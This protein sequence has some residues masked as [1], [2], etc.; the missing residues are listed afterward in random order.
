MI[1]Q[2]LTGKVS[3]VMPVYNAALFLR[4][5]IQSI[6]SQTFSDFEFLIINDG[7]TDDS[8]A[9]IEEIN[10]PRIKHV[11]L[12]QN[13]GI[14][15]ALNLGIE[16][17]AGEYLVRMDADD[18][19]RT[20]RLEM[21]VSFMD[22]NPEI[23]L[24]GSWV[25]YFGTKNGLIKTP[26]SH[27]DI[28]WTLLSGSAIFHPSVIMRMSIIRN[29]NIRYSSQYLHAEDFA[30]WVD[31]SMKTQL[32]NIP[33]P[34][35]SYRFSKSSVSSKFASIQRNN[36]DKIRRNMHEQLLGENLS[37]A[38]WNRIGGDDRVPATVAR[39]I[40]VYTAMNDAQS[41]FPAKE[42]EKKLNIRLKQL[43][44]QKGC[45]WSSR[46]WLLRNSFKDI[47]FLKYFAASFVKTRLK[48]T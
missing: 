27:N 48:K 41:L 11:K 20:D 33:E 44:L 29:F 24:A 30:L 46:S 47:T 4:E 23:G 9:I 28:L 2:P 18:I 42:F 14:V 35:L 34:L 12:S 10:D 15:E 1:P 21:Q 7:S 40:T 36:A 16:L 22:S 26:V 37:D 17:A 5:A 8:T 31:L 6:L 43:I 25:N 45:N 32:A 39:I 13:K 3:I 19:S 38:D